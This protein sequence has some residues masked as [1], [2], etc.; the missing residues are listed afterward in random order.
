MR[1]LPD[2]RSIVLGTCCA[3][4]LGA[5]ACAGSV[6]GQGVFVAEP[7]ADGIFLY[8][9]STPGGGR[10][11]SLVVD[12]SDGLLVVEAQPTPAAASELLAALDTR[13][14]KPV[15]YLVL[16]HAHA[17]AAGGAS[18]FPESTVVIGSAACA[19]ALSDPGYD[20]GAE[21]RL[22]SS[23]PEQW[24]APPRVSLSL[25]VRA[26][27]DLPDPRQPAQLRVHPRAHSV[28]DLTVF[29]PEAS[30]LYLGGLLSLDRNPYSGDANI[31]RWLGMLNS[32]I[33]DAPRTIVGLHGSVSDLG[34]LIEQRDRF[35][36]LRGRVEEGFIDRVP[37]EEIAAQVMADPDTGK[38]FAIRAEPSFVGQLVDRVVEES[39]NQRKKRGLL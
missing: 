19:E 16:S 37:P 11:N 8:R 14:A 23:S 27:I 20:F 15:R 1:G 39:V 29:F 6:A 22:R 34:K 38:H 32:V 25:G 3:A 26:T 5:A 13:F 9:P 12:R 24:E 2:F 4:A 18:A 35:A 10:A 28:G 33:V 17:E 36:W 7:V 30:V 21:Q 31:G